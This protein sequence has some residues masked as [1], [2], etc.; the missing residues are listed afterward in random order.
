MLIKVVNFLN[1]FW[2]N[3]KRNFFKEILLGLGVILASMVLIISSTFGD[4]IEKLHKQSILGKIPINEIK[5]NGSLKLNPKTIY[6]ITPQ[7]IKLIE[8]MKEVNKVTKISK[9]NFP[10]SVLITFKPPPIISLV[11]G[12]PTK[13]FFIEMPVIGIP[14]SLANPYISKSQTKKGR[15]D[16]WKN[17]YNQFQ[18]NDA[19]IIKGKKILIFLKLILS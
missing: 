16:R 18:L 9:A 11:A 15:I 12:V 5:I 13:T 7:F 4:G 17:V 1:L 19:Q 6:N 14:D 8:E 2:T 3:L 10:V